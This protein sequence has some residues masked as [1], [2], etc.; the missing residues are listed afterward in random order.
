MP[1]IGDLLAVI[2]PGLFQHAYVVADLA[3]AEDGLRSALGC[4]PWVELPAADLTYDLRGTPTTCALAIGF[5]RSGDVQVELIQPVR[6]DGLHAEFLAERG[7]GVHH[8][9][10]LVDDLDASLEL[11]AA[12]GAPAVMGARFGSLRFAYVDTASELGVYAELVED[13]D[14]MMASIMPWRDA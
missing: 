8:L 3:A 10:F 11:A 1:G 5:A 9:G 4:D 13:P 2:G 14:A 6:G 7:P 12:C